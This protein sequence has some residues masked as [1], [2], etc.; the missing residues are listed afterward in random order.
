MPGGLPAVIDRNRTEA[1]KRELFAKYGGG[2]NA[3]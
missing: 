2:N 3:S 1:Q